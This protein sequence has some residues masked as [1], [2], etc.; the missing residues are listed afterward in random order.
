MRSE[1]R[2]AQLLDFEDGALAD[3]NVSGSSLTVQLTYAESAQLKINRRLSKIF[4]YKDILIHK[5]FNT[6]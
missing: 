5:V 3:R 2:R 1:A 4:I 6:L